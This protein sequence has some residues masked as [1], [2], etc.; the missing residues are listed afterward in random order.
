ML[1]KDDS[2]VKIYT[3]AKKVDSDDPAVFAAR[4]EEQRGIGNIDKA[5]QLGERLALLTPE[6]PEL[7]GLTGDKIV[8]ASV[9]YQMRVLLVFTAKTSLESL[10]PLASLSSSAVSAMLNKLI[11][12]SEGFFANISDGAAFTFYYLPLR[13]GVD[14]PKKIGAQFAVL[15]GKDDKEYYKQLGENLYNTVHSLVNQIINELGFV[16]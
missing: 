1:P 3:G 12:T 11:E 10:L 13:K 8:S 5:K 16:F 6:S 7:C 15:C 14:V 4:V 2:D 9:S